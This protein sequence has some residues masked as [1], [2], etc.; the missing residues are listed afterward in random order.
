MTTLVAQPS[1]LRDPGERTVALVVAH[2]RLMLLMLLF[3]A[4]VIAARIADG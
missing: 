2:Q 4:G 1:R 3:M